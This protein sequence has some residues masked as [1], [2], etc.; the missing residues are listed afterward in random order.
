MDIKKTGWAKGES[1]Q[2]KPLAMGLLIA[3]GIFFT[4]SFMV[5]VFG[6]AYNRGEITSP[7]HYRDFSAT[8]PIGDK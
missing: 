1:P 5:A 4:F 8:K 3:F 7:N 2:A 6:C